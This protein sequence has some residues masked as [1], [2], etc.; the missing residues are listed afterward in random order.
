MRVHFNELRFELTSVENKKI[1]MTNLLEIVA[2]AT[3][4]EQRVLKNCRHYIAK[5]P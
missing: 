5:T 4:L 3:R 1:S 2:L